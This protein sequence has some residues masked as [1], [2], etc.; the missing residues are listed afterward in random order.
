MGKVK[1]VYVLVKIVAVFN[2]DIVFFGEWV[3]VWEGGM[4]DGRRFF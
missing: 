3:G 2:L 4:D 1:V